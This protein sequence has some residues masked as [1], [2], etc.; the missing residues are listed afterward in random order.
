MG[1]G[2]MRGVEVTGK[3]SDVEISFLEIQQVGF[4]GIMVKH[5]PSCAADT[6]HP[7]LVYRNISIHDNYIHD[8]GAE[9]LYIGFSFWAEDRCTSDVGGWAHNI[10]GLRIY[11]NL[12]ERCHWDGIQVGSAPVDVEIFN[13]TLVETGFDGAP[14]SGYGGTGIQLGAGTTGLVHGNIIINTK[15]GGITL[16]GVGNNII[17]NNL[18]AGAGGGMFIDNRP[19]DKDYPGGIP[20]NQP[21]ERQ[22]Q[23]GS[24]YYIYNNTFVDIAGNVMWTMSAFTD[25][26]FKNNLAVAANAQEEGEIEFVNFDVPAEYPEHPM[27]TGEV[28]GN[29][30]QNDTSGLSFADPA[31]Y[32]FRLLNTSAGGVDKGVPLPNYVTTDFQGIARPQG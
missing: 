22:T 24:P 26:H 2:G 10:E 13:N 9:G 30:F 6:S 17:Y 16:F 31:N 15:N 1:G 18:I 3:S 7:E 11:N 4:A 25:N 19:D 12:I 5:D 32:D 29:V 8:I 14:G 27:P 23:I 20:P 28:E 21:P